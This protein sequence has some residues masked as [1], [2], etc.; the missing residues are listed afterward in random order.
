MFTQGIQGQ[1]SAQ[2]S[3]LELVCNANYILQTPLPTMYLVINIED[4]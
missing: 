2:V 1:V 4:V 3:D